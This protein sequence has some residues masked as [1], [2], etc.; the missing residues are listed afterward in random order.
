MRKA[1]WLPVAVLVLLSFDVWNWNQNEPILLFLPAWMWHVAVVTFLFSLAF[2][3]VARY[4]W[5]EE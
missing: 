5:R 2:Y 1:W 3:L 4:E